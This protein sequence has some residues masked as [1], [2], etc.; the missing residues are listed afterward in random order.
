MEGL[1]NGSE[2]VHRRGVRYVTE[3]LAPA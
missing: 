3:A 2:A 1:R